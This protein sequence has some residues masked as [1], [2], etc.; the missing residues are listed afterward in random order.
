MDICRRKQKKRKKEKEE[1]KERW[2][3][4]EMLAKFFK[5]WHVFHV[6]QIFLYEL[7]VMKA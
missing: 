6:D 3:Y 4:A 1:K 2:I 5:I 7:T